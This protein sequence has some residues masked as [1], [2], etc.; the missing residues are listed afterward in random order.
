METAYG[1][2]SAVPSGADLVGFLE[3]SRI[4]RRSTRQVHGSSGRAR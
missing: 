3:W 4:E 1:D 2:P